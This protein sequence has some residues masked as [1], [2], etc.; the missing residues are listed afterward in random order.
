MFQRLLKKED[1]E[2]IFP[3]AG[4]KS[5]LASSGKELLL[6]YDRIEICFAHYKT[7]EAPCYHKWVGAAYWHPRGDGSPRTW[8]GTWSA[9]PHLTINRA[10]ILA[11]HAARAREAVEVVEDPSLEEP[12]TST[13]EIPQGRGQGRLKRSVEETEEEYLEQMLLDELQLADTPGNRQISGAVGGR[14]PR[15]ETSGG[16]L[17]QHTNAQ[18]AAQEATR[19]EWNMIWEFEEATERPHGRPGDGDVDMP[20]TCQALPLQASET[21]QRPRQRAHSRGN[22]TRRMSR[23]K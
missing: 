2:K 14:G 3:I 11:I 15:L 13:P 1:I 16:D 22:N 18:E 6:T 10:E 17:S 8:K 21:T 23:W 9:G 5:H 12:V 7:N 19:E 4:N 20:P